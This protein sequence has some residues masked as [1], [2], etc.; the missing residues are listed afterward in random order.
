MR[1]WDS[2]LPHCIGRDMQLCGRTCFFNS[3]NSTTSLHTKL[4]QISP[5]IRFDFP[6]TAGDVHPTDGSRAIALATADGFVRLFDLRRLFFPCGNHLFGFFDRSS[7]YLLQCWILFSA[8]TAL[9]M[10][11]TQEAPQPYQ[12]VRPLGLTSQSSFFREIRLDYGPLFITSVRFE[13]PYRTLTL[14]LPQMHGR[15]GINKQSPGRRLLVSHMYSPV[16]LFDLKRPEETVE[17]LSIFADQVSQV[18]YQYS[19]DVNDRF[20]FLIG[21]F[22]CFSRTSQIGEILLKMKGPYLRVDLVLESHLR[23]LKGLGP[24]SE[25]SW[26]MIFFYQR[27]IYTPNFTI[28]NSCSIKRLNLIFYCQLDKNR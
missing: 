25:V 4:P 5:A 23:S 7:V 10:D 19:G 13:P 24:S 22:C 12:I 27:S 17:E 1:L 20:V 14:S 26:F 9:A 18:S 8:T 3:V 11:L 15:S 28:F 6:V 21:K 2:R 16:F